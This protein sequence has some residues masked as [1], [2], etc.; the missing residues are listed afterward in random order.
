MVRKLIILMIT[1][2][3]MLL[4][5]PLAASASFAE[6]RIYDEGN[7]LSQAEL[8]DCTNRLKQAADRTGMNIGIVLGV[9]NRSEYT[10]TALADSTYD[11]MFGAGTDGLLYYMDL[12]GHSP[13]IDHITT[14]GMGHFY[15]TNSER[16]DRV[17]MIFDTLD[18]Y[19]K[20]AGSED[21]WGAL[22][23]FADEVEM[24]YEAGVPER[25][26]YYD[27]LDGRYYY[28]SAN[29]RITSSY[30]RP[31]K[32]WGGVLLM[33]FGAF[34]M[35]IVAAVVVYFVTLSRY[36]FKYSLSPT[37]YVN[38]KNVVYNAQH[39]HF[40]RSSTS[41]VAINSGSS[42]GGGSHHHHSG[43]GHSHGGHGGGS[44]RR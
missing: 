3:A 17:G 41:K 44:H 22:M 34:G 31:Y 11:Q 9:Q 27:D 19:L 40:V 16:N 36:K 5:C 20:P 6:V 1:G 32:D 33:T 14:S 12:K 15:Y 7:K 38:K 39:D 10:I 4:C 43:G 30:G 29:G 24:Y 26:Y 42:G 13:A 2:L 28:L 37:T 23:Q 8:D 18:A 25:Y 21:V 35:G